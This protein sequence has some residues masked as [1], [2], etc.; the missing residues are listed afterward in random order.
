MSSLE[1]HNTMWMD[2][3]MERWREGGVEK[4][5]R[6]EV[7]DVFIL[8]LTGKLSPPYKKVRTYYIIWLAWRDSCMQRTGAVFLVFCWLHKCLATVLVEIVLYFPCAL[9]PFHIFLRIPLDVYV[10]ENPRWWWS[11]VWWHSIGGS[12]HSEI[13]GANDSVDLRWV[14]MWI[15]THILT[16]SRSCSVCKFHCPASWAQN[17][18]LLFG[19]GHIEYKNAIWN[20]RDTLC[21]L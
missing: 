19:V 3:M 17:I 11:V 2:E 21:C 6:A 7:Q 5:R 20:V 13:A 14:G 12:L 1:W 16:I 9:A 18:V 15:C 4:E 8:H 10:R